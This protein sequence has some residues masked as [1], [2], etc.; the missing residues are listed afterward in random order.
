MINYL[1]RL[2]LAI[3]ILTIGLIIASLLGKLVSRLAKKLK[4]D[5]ILS[6]TGL[7]E[8]LKESN[9][10]LSISDLLGWVVKWFIIIAVLL[11]ISDMLTLTAVSI[12]LNKVLLYIPNVVVAIIIITIGLVV[13]N[14]VSEL[15]KKSI[16]TSDFVSP[17]SAKML[18]VA[19]KWLIVVFSIMASLSQLEIAPQLIQ[20]LFTGIIMMFSLAGG[21]AFGLGGK[22]KAR[23]I[24][25]SMDNKN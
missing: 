21:I 11:T 9:I 7:R 23:E 6:T 3:L 13:G 25:N 4:L 17:A 15:V 12:F 20:S 19:T 24:I 22:D 8:K 18:S 10:N 16:D 2:A 1:P 14:F 5:K